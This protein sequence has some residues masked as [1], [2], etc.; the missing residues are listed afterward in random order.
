MSK[1]GKSTE[2]EGDLWFAGAEVGMGSDCSQAWGF[3]WR[4]WKCSKIGFG[5]GCTGLTMLKTTELDTVKRWLLW[6]IDSNAGLQKCHMPCFSI[7]LHCMHQLTG[8]LANSTCGQLCVLLQSSTITILWMNRNWESL[9]G[10]E[11]CLVSFSV[12]NGRKVMPESWEHEKYR[13]EKRGVGL[14]K[15]QKTNRWDKYYKRK[16]HMTGIQ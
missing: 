11:T 9:S 15:T 1:I 3:L 6:W 8:R 2:T 14:S 16:I 4:W 5:D 13:K 7:T 10:L 12:L